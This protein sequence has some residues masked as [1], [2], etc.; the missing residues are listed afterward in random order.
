MQALVVCRA[1]GLILIGM[2]ML[3]CSEAEPKS[4]EDCILKKVK[5]GMSDTAVALVTQA[6][7]SKFSAALEQ[8]E[9]KAEDLREVYSQ[10]KQYQDTFDI[11]L[12]NGSN[13]ALSEVTFALRIGKRV[14]YYRVS[15]DSEPLQVAKAVLKI[16]PGT[17]VNGFG[18]CSAKGIRRGKG[19][20]TAQQSD[21]DGTWLELDAIIEGA[22]INQSGLCASGRQR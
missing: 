17:G 3:A 2:T 7:H 12:Y 21:P 13:I 16:I 20:T 18:L 14:R 10:G 5:A 15:V 19:G 4:Y 9:F 11:T 1:L 6:C 8:E 22:L